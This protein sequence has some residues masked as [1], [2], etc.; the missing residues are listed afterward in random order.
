MARAISLDPRAARR[1]LILQHNEFVARS[2][3]RHLREH[4]DAIDVRTTPS[5]SGDVLGNALLRPTHVVIGQNFGPREATGDRVVP[6]WRA[7]YPSIERVV[8]LTAEPDLPATLPGVDRVIAKD[9]VVALLPELRRA[10]LDG[11]EH[12]RMSGGLSD[13]KQKD[14]P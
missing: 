9:Q 13:P 7:Q 4:F 5:A 3:A 11:D 6:A 12:P 2:I 14:K 10:L 8:L 1:L